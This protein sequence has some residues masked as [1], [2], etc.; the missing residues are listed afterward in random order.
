MISDSNNEQQR[1]L[2]RF[3]SQ[4]KSFPPVLQQKLARVLLANTLLAR[5]LLA[6]ALLANTLLARALLVN[7]LLARALL[8]NMLLAELLCE[9]HQCA[10]GSAPP[11]RG[12]HSVV[13]SVLK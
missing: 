8:A 6:R 11:V 10:R 9:G 4:L 5:V 7:T 3:H 1:F 12:Q 2:L 13:W